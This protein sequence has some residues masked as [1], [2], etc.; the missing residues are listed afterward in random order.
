M[1][2]Y[3]GTCAALLVCVA[4]C[5]TGPPL[6]TYLLTPPLHSAVVPGQIA[7]TPRILVPRV[8]VPDYL[9][10]TDIVLR[11]G[12]NE[13]KVSATGR[14]GERLSHGL[15]RELAAELG[16]RLPT[17]KVMLDRL[18]SA[19]SR[20]LIDVSALDLWPDGRCAMAAT[21]A[22]VETATPHAVIYGSGTFDSSPVGST[23]AVDDGRLVDAVSRTVGKL[24]DAIALNMT[25]SAG[26]SAVGAE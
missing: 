19:Q 26:R 9:D 5:G 25:Q 10:T 21:W 7:P 3:A 8:L 23:I 6:R 2:L 11:D 17:D 14:W 15:T 24:A 1:R 18:G 16:A 4:A 12:S 13:V 22:I 20:L